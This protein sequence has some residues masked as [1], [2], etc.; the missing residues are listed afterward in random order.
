[1]RIAAILVSRNRPDLVNDTVNFI[2]NNSPNTDIC[3]VESG[4]DQKN[5]TKHTTLW[6]SDEDYRGKVFAHNIG[7]EYMRMSGDYNYYWFL[8]NDTPFVTTKFDVGKKL[9]RILEKNKQIG[10]LSPTSSTDSYASSHPQKSRKPRMVTTCDYLNLMMSKDT[11][12]QVGFL[13][14]SFK[15]SWGAIHELSYKLNE[16]GL[17]VA[18][19]DKITYRHLGGST[20][21]NKTNTIKREEYQQRAKEFAAKYFVDNY[22][23]NWDEKFW[24]RAKKN[25]NIEV[26][27]YS[28]HRDFWEKKNSA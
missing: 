25:F 26:N 4:T 17:G 10:V 23:K 27:T 15:Y 3:V 20:Y 28:L 14:P 11:V 16:I 24:K 5:L 8:M 13:N 12:H 1:M 7:L 2:S 19:T 9:A 21:T 18:Y 22:G 6:Y